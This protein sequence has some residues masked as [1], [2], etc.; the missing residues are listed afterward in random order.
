M[1][2][3]WKTKSRD[4]LSSC[5]QTTAEVR[6]KDPKKAKPENGNAVANGSA[7]GGEEKKKGAE[8]KPTL[9]EQINVFCEKK[10]KSCVKYD[11]YCSSVLRFQ[12]QIDLSRSIHIQDNF[13]SL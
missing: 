4:G 7:A 6:R 2:F 5:D 8:K 1:G 11:T 12:I 9:Q 10:G 3:R 13:R